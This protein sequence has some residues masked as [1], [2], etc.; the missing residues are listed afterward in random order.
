[1]GSPVAADRRVEAGGGA[2]PYDMAISLIRP[3]VAA[4]LPADRRRERDPR[5]L[6]PRVK[7]IVLECL[8]RERLT[9]NLLEIR[10]LVGELTED[11]SAAAP[12]PVPPNPRPAPPVQLADEA[13]AKD[14][15]PTE[16]SPI[17]FLAPAAPLPATEKAAASATIEEAKTRVRP[18]L[19][20]R[21]DM[22]AASRLPRD[23]LARQIGRI[24]ADILAEAEIRLN[25]A[26]QHDLI[27]LLIDDMRGLGP[28]EP[29][30]ADESIT[31]IMVNG[32]DQVYV[33]QGGKLRLSA[34]RFRDNAHVMNIAQRIVT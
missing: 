15:S 28:L 1:M 26:E 2:T 32:P 7:E 25:A 14:A 27:T 31:D 10:T 18:V 33:E 6:A 9:L 12:T 19:I 20:E 23:E 11:L 13:P 21:I 8:A 4:R 17:A 16:D 29:L 5:A 24:V 34:A 3:A 22:A 30:L